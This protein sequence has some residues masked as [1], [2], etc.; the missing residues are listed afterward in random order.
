MHI[1]YKDLLAELR[2]NPAYA[3]ELAD[4]HDILYIYFKKPG[5]KIASTKRLS[6]R[7]N[8]IIDLDAKGE[9]IGMELL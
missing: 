8:I 6:T 9:A 5:T 1:L 3:E 4:S 7:E 2:K